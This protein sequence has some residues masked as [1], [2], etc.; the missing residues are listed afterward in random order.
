MGKGNLGKPLGSLWEIFGKPGKPWE[1]LGMSLWELLPSAVDL[2][3][4]LAGH[5]RCS[6]LAAQGRGWAVVCNSCRVRAVQLRVQHH[7]PRRKNHCTSV[8][9]SS[10]QYQYPVSSINCGLSV[11]SLSRLASCCVIAAR[12]LRGVEFGG[13]Q[14]GDQSC[15]QWGGRMDQGAGG[16][17]IE[18]PRSG[19]CRWRR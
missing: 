4:E 9:V 7:Q 13:L 8:Q 16:T 17:V 12:F 2:A 3:V 11:H 19:S 1:A 18:G 14:D 15:G 5:S 6:Q 10:I